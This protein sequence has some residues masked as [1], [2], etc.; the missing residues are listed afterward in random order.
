[1]VPN[2]PRQVQ[3]EASI[4]IYKFRSGQSTADEDEEFIYKYCIVKYNI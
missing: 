3:M 1:M 2:S 4:V